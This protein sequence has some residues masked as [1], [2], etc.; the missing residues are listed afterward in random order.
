M[1]IMSIQGAKNAVTVINYKC[2]I[3]YLSNSMFID[4]IYCMTHHEKEFILQQARHMPGP[5]KN[6]HEPKTALPF[7]LLTF[8]AKNKNR[9][10]VKTLD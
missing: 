2:N 3:T 1:L 10:I 8:K 9:I 7:S 4:F 5:E 6:L